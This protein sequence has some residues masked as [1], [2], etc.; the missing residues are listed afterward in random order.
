MAEEQEACL[1]EERI[2]WKGT[3]TGNR[4]DI[5]TRK[6]GSWCKV[7]SGSHSEGASIITQKADKGRR[8]GDKVV[9]GKEQQ[10]GL[11]C[12]AGGETSGR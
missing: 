11:A 1:S 12:R 4:T 9:V 8:L 5:H 6:E 7:A 3:K 2:V 10:W